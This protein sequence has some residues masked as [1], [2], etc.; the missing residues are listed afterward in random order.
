[1]TIAI[2][3]SLLSGLIIGLIIGYLPGKRMLAQQEKHH[4]EADEALA[5]R[6]RENADVM[7]A[8]FEETIAKMRQEVLNTTSV[9][10]RERQDEF[11]R[12]SNETLGRIM[13]PLQENI[14]RMREAVRDNTDTSNKFSGQLQASLKNVALHSMAAKESADRLA[15]ALTAGSKIQGDLGETILIRL[16]ETTGLKAGI[17]FETQSFIRDE[18]G[19][20]V[21]GDGGRALQPD[22]IVHIEP[23]HDVIIDSKVSTTAFYYYTQA[24]TDLERKKYLKQHV[25]SVRNHVREL[26]RKDYSKHLNGAL[27]YVIMF[28]P[29][30]AALFAATTEDVRLWRDAMDKKVYIVDEQTLYA[31]LKI[32]NLNWRQQ[33]Q[34]ENHKQ[35]FA[36]AEEMVERVEKFMGKYEEVGKALKKAQ[37]MYDDAYAKLKDSG[38]SIPT[39]AR[40]I[41]ALSSASESEAK[42]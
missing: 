35:V 8:R 7:N 31:A 38:Q 6:Y 5:A 12:Q 4:K 13:Q 27:D 41:R 14:I 40:K 15:N 17:H 22:V 33:R 2:I 25:E 24:E 30:S 10:L 34:I 19:N 36:L 18:K 39:T 32:I 37:N 16:L 1:M 29:I 23:G 28:M 3:L 26:A 20:R 9:M 42:D 21:L 11:S